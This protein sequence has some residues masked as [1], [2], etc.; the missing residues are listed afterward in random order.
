MNISMKIL[1]FIFVSMTAI[2]VSY[3]A[4]RDTL[5]YFRNNWDF[6]IDNKYSGTTYKIDGPHEDYK[7]RNR[8]RVFGSP[9]ILSV[10]Y[11]ALFVLILS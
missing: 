10:L 2:I 11:I 5:F 9:L 4:Y 6:N 3:K 8:R 1:P 7:E